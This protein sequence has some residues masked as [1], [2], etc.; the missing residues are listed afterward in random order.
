LKLRIDFQTPDLILLIFIFAVAFVLAFLSYRFTLPPLKAREKVL[1]L[2]LRW[3]VL[4]SLF[5]ALG[6]ALVG[7]TKK[8]WEKPRI[9]LLLDSSRSMN[10]KDKAVSRKE[11]LQNLLAEKS[12]KEVRSEAEIRPYLFSDSLVPY[13]LSGKLPAFS[14]EATSI[15]NSLEKLKENLRGEELTSV[16]LISDGTNNAGEDPIAIARNYTIPVYTVGIGEF[17]PFKDLSLEKVKYDEIAYSGENDTVKVT[18]KNQGYK[19]VKIPVLLQE[20]KKV[21]AR[22]ELSFNISGELQETG[23]VFEPEEEGTHRY[24]V[25]IPKAQGESFQ[26]N[27]LKSFTQKVLKKRFNLLLVSQSLN[28]EFSFLKRLL[29]LNNDIIFEALVFSKSGKPLWSGL[30]RGKKIEDFDLVVVLDAPQFLIQNQKEIDDLLQKKGVSLL[31]SAGEEFYK[32]KDMLSSFDFLPFEFDKNRKPLFQSFNLNLTPEGKIHPLTR[33]SEEPEE[34][35]FLWA[36]LPPFEKMLPLK[37]KD[38]AKVLAQMTFGEESIPGIIIQEREKQKIEVLGFSPLWKWDF[39]LWGIGKDNSAYKKFWENSFRWLLSREDLERFKIYIDKAV[40]KKGEEIKFNSRVFDESY[41]KIKGAEI[42]IKVY[43]KGKEADSLLFNLMP[44]DGEY[45]YTLSFLPPGE[46]LFKGEARKEEIVL[47]SYSGK[48]EIEDV[49][50]EDEDLKP[51]KE[52]LKE[53]AQLSGGDYS[54]PD[55]FAALLKRLDLEKKP[56]LEIKEIT[57]WDKPLLLFFFIFFLSL[58]WFFRKRFQLL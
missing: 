58:E 39:L 29:N 45:Y 12:F 17:V 7:M 26:Q 8:S 28:W 37:A 20:N 3:L 52:L 13:I 34:N 33:L 49:S 55:D 54:E 42:K 50:L 30:S 16:I 43:P 6:E 1:L 27:N 38:G 23:L 31:L 25:V 53:I 11:V 5:L 19:G 47:G 10:I 24:Q 2:V 51:D 32:R 46:Y 21:L 48:F 35:L 57:L 22:K 40:Y 18:V 14:G 44:E 36:N 41:Q 56:R 15:G 4:T 9:A